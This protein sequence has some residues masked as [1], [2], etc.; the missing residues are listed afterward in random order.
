MKAGDQ[1]TA[2]VFVAKNGAPVEICRSSCSPDGHELMTTGPAPAAPPAPARSGGAFRASW[3]ARRRGLAADVARGLQPSRDWES[4]HAK[5]LDAVSHF[6]DGRDVLL[7]WLAIPGDSARA[8]GRGPEPAGP[9]P[10]VV[11]AGGPV[12]RL[13]AGSATRRLRPEP[14]PLRHW[15]QKKGAGRRHPLSA[16]GAGGDDE[17]EDLDRT[18]SE[19]RRVDGPA[20]PLLRA[21]GRAAHLPVADQDEVHS[22]S[23][24]RVHPVRVRSVLSESCG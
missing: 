7:A 11:Q 9:K 19:V 13:G 10:G 24:S 5:T 1:V 2:Y 21:A 4:S 18:R 14:Q 8:S 22:D 20:G 15:R 16:V 12:R 23:G 3:C 6:S 17:G